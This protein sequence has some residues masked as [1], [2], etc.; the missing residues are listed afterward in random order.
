M[1]SPYFSACGDIVPRTYEAVDYDVFNSS[2]S[3]ATVL[4]LSLK[5]TIEFTT[6]KKYRL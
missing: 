2:I 3:S 5:F 4:S 6:L 1:A